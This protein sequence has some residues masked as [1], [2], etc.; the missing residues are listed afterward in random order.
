MQRRRSRGRLRALL[1]LIALAGLVFVGLG[2]CRSGPAPAIALDSKLPGIGKKTT[3]EIKIEEPRRGVGDVRVE[4]VQGERT[5][6]L[7][8]R[9]HETLPPWK[10]WGHAATKTDAFTVDVGSQVQKGLKEGEATIRVTASRAGSWLRHPAAETREL[11][12]PVQLRPPTLQVMSSKTYVA[13]GGC[14]TVVYHVGESSVRDGVEAGAW[15]FA[16]YPLPGGDARARFALFSVPYDLGEPTAVKLVARDAVGNE[17]RVAFI[18]QFFAKPFASDTIKLDDAFLNKVVPEIMG[19]TPDLQDKGNLLDNYLEINGELRRKNNKTLLEL[20]EKSEPRFLWNGPFQ[21]MRNAQ[22]MSSFA[23]RRTY[24]YQGRAVDKQ[25]HLGF[26]LASIRMSEVQAANSGKVALARYFGIYGNAVVI[27]HGY[28]LFSLYA[29]L[30]SLGVKEG[31]S[32][33]K[34]QVIG[35]SG[36]T[37]LAGGDHLHFS[38]LVHGLAVNPRE[39]WDDHWIRDRLKL[40]LGA[41]LPMS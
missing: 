21:P 10:V 29:H 24:V 31:E 28:G 1:I 37:G 14:E 41:A 40:K 36:Q 3:I 18:D 30:S 32:V 20:A 9:K 13:Q 34:G 33:N 5:E 2:S 8:E 35:R 12:L 19:E 4:L 7:A 16:G 15:F 22:V 23:D 17:S 26:D 6:L 25:D 27:D 38:I 11:K 39:W